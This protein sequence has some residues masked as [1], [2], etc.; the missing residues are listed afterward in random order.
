MVTAEAPARRDFPISIVRFCFISSMCLFPQGKKMWGRQWS[1]KMDSGKKMRWL[2]SE[3]ISNYLAHCSI[4]CFSRYVRFRHLS[5]LKI[6]DLSPHWFRLTIN[7][8]LCGNPVEP[9]GSGFPIASLFLCS[10][11][12]DAP[13]YFW[14]FSVSS[15][16]REAC[17]GGLAIARK[18][19]A[20]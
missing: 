8:C 15:P 2:L 10:Y 16:M 9:V 3:L 20:S 6:S 18:D 19:R 11:Q 17:Q 4:P 13:P 7:V 1:K 14:H 5:R 12:L